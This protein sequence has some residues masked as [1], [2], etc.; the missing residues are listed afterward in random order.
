MRKIILTFILNVLLPLALFSQEEYTDGLNGPQMQAD[1]TVL[2]VPF[3]ELVVSRLDYLV[4]DT[5][6]ETSQLGMMVWDLTDDTLLYARNPRHL[7]RTASTMKHLTA[8]TALDCLG[9]AHRF[10]TS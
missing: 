6:M 5:L 9:G 7:M 3:Q 8:I 10:T 1:S 4:D 2:V